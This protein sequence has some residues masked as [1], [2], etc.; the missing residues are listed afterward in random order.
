MS[1]D[2]S[3]QLTPAD[4]VEIRK[5]GETIFEMGQPGDVMYI[6]KSG[7]VEIRVGDRI[8]DCVEP[9]A[10]LGEMAILDDAVRSAT[11]V[12]VTDCE[13]VAIDKKRLLDMVQREPLVAIE[14]TKSM[15]RRL[16]SMNYMAQYD[17]LTRL[18]NRTLFREHCQ[19]AL[20]RALRSGALVGMLH[21]D[22]DNFENINDSLGYTA[23][24]GLLAQVASRLTTTLRQADTL[25]RLGADEFAVLVEVV[26][27]ETDLAI[28]AQ[29]MLDA[30][31]DPF[32]IDGKT[33]YISASIG[34]SCHPGEGSNVETLLT[35]AD[36]A[37]HAAKQSGRN[38]YAFFTRELNAKALEFLTLKSALRESIGKNELAL[39]YQ[40]RVDVASGRILGVE[41]LLRWFHPT[42][43]FISPARFIPI[44][45]ETGLIES[46]GEWVLRTGC[47]QQ[48]AWMDAGMPRTR[49]AIN[50]S[51]V[52]M[53]QP[54]LV[55]KVTGILTETG[56]PADCLEL[57]ITESLLVDDP[58]KVVEKLRAFRAMGIAIALDDFGTGYSS[59][60]YLKRFPMDCMKID[61]SFVRG[62][63][64]DA[65]DVAI[66]RT[67]IALARNLGLKVVVEGVETE[68][69]L[70]FATTEGCDEFQ[71]YLF[72]KPLPADNATTL[73]RKG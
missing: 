16:R 13:F 21:L 18:P 55:G 48:K 43:G 63:P 71:G 14:M 64:Q 19:N 4:K 58:E 3:T 37:M 49:M 57:E 12:A 54:D 73:L 51:A 35:N 11:A 20:Q 47:R 26:R 28:T 38:Q 52:Q 66:T 56:L 44:A 70:A 50:L 53:R 9:G 41:A 1:F 17:L 6:I 25:A 34:I 33:L 62:I 5:A 60:S 7:K 8:F 31:A 39:H 27:E 29:R 67:I 69:Q 61:Q 24:D 42:L 72:S 30:L 68:A 36:A 46:I 15:V 65:D 22:V 32:E 45:E 2:Y 59:L 40:P 10:T 23:A